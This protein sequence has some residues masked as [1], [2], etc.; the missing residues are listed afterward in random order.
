MPMKKNEVNNKHTQK[1]GKLNTVLSIWYLRRKRF[2]DGRLMKQ[3]S[4][5]YAHGGI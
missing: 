4:R 3:K 5:L 2:P 1:Y